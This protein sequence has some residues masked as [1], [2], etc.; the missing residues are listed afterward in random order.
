ME[1]NPKTLHRA[2]GPDTSKEAAYSIHVSKMEQVVL[3]TILAYGSRGCISDEI[4]EALSATKY[5]YSTITARYK[6]LK[7]KGL[8]KV[9]KRT[10][11]GR[12]GRQQQLMWATNFYEPEEF[13][14]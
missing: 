7:D 4:Q 13:L 9:D 3:N 6:A 8:V 11:K 12:S 5:A 1:T 2:V 14:L 10:M